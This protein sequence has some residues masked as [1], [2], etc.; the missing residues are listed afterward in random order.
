MAATAIVRPESSVLDYQ[1]GPDPSR[2]RYE[3][4]SH[5]ITIPSGEASAR[6]LIRR[7]LISVYTQCGKGR[8]MV[9][10]F[11]LELSYVLNRSFM[12]ALSCA[13][14]VVTLHAIPF[15]IPFTLAGRSRPL[16]TTQIYPLPVTPIR[17]P[18]V[19]RFPLSTM[20]P[21]SPHAPPA[22]AFKARQSKGRDGY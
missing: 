8:K 7:P 11:F 17:D 19:L 22:A 10:T 9:A 5:S 15:F 1:P 20:H 12:T 3:D 18:R 21:K 6:L 13:P 14:G 4:P 2:R 16:H